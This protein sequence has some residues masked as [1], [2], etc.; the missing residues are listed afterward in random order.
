MR[1]FEAQSAPTVSTGVATVAPVAE[2]PP[3]TTTAP[4]ATKQ[5]AS[6]ETGREGKKGRGKKDAAAIATATVA[7]APEPVTEPEIVM[8]TVEVFIEDITGEPA[9]PLVEEQMALEEIGEQLAELAEEVMAANIEDLGPKSYADLFKRAEGKKEAAVPQKKARSGSNGRNKKAEPSVE[10][11]TAP[12][13]EAA[14]VSQAQVKSPP[15]VSLFV[16]QLPVEI[17]E[18]D[19]LRI[20]SGAC[21]ADI[22]S[23]KG[24]GFIEFPEPVF[25]ASMMTRYQEEPDYFC[26][27]G[28]KLK[29]EER[30]VNPKGNNSG[31]KGSNQGRGG[32]N[33]N[34][35]SSS[36]GKQGNKQG[37]GK[38]N[39]G[40]GEKGGWAIQGSGGKK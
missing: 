8:S 10:P 2:E 22:H 12:Q 6:N 20:F 29:V 33:E 15:G 4:T 25:A 23:S 17:T 11:S 5:H 39:A 31:G 40:K 1:L 30:T 14:P 38:R 21:R 32:K 35:A 7:P 37:G 16:K 36:G 18:S 3:A 13:T 34:V 27:G 26:H 19:L 9:M 28:Q 24:Y